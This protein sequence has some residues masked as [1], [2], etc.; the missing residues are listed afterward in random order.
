MKDRIFLDTNIL[1]YAY[2]RTESQKRKIAL[3]ILTL[4][5]AIIS[6]QVVNEFV[7]VM[8]RKFN[9]CLIFGSWLFNFI[10]RRYAGG[11]NN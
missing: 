2:S 1:I 9:N 5:K 10:Y 7:W 11:S 6:T 3:E 4:E 8:Y